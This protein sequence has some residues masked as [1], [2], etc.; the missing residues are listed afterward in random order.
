MTVFGKILVFLNLLF[1][2]VTGA[3]IVFVF[4]TRANW[5]SAYN[6]AKTKVEAVDAAYRTERTAHENDRKQAEATEQALR[7]ERKAIDDQLT[8]ALARNDELQ[9][10]ANNQTALKNGSDTELQRYQA[11]ENQF[12]SEREAMVQEKESLR[13]RII[14]VQKE[15]DKQRE[16]AVTADLQAK[17]MFQKANNLLRQVE[18]LTARNRELEATGVPG[19]GGVGGGGRSAVDETV[20]SAPPGVR[21]KI[22]GVG[23]STGMAQINIGSDSGLSPGNILIVY[24]GADYVGDLEVT[25]AEPKVAVGRFKPKNRNSKLEVGDSVITSFSGSPQ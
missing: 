6:D 17:N 25:T 4:T 16:V 19:G 10:V 5:V 15:L 9:K 2:V 22:T 11:M 18:E 20:K 13:G 21:G 24:R 12:K 8:S 1:S 14:A 23:A 7:Q 3:L